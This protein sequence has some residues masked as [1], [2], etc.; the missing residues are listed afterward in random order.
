MHGI[1]HTDE[2]AE[3]TLGEVL[4]ALNGKNSL[5]EV[6]EHGQGKAST[7]DPRSCVLGERLLRI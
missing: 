4:S 3:S 7:I 2:L 5:G 6:H 1:L